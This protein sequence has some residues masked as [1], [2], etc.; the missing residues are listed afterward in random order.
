VSGP[1]VSANSDVVDFQWSPDSSRLAYRADQDTD[2]V[3]ELYSSLAAGGDNV[4]VSGPLVTNGDV[5]DFS[6]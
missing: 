1:L 4:K 5:F 6:W 2:G 3:N